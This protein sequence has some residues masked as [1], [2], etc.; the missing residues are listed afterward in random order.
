MIPLLWALWAAVTAL[1]AGLWVWGYRRGKVWAL[2]LLLPSGML[3][4][5]ILSGWI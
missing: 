5:R 4:S 3:V 2:L 1:L